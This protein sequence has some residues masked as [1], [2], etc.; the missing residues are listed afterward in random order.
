MLHEALIIM[1]LS[2]IPLLLYRPAFGWVRNKT[3]IVSDEDD[4]LAVKPPLARRWAGP[5]AAVVRTCGR[6]L[7]A[8]LFLHLII[9]LA[10]VRGISSGGG[11]FAPELDKWQ[12]SRRRLMYAKRSRGVAARLHR[13]C[14][15][16]RGEPRSAWTRFYVFL[17]VL[18]RSVY[19]ASVSTVN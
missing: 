11:I 14:V 8:W 6:W 19:E 9:L 2:S 7:R 1:S 12:V 10:L 15:Y 3:R 5:A 18:L 17:R 16:V 13:K 4:A